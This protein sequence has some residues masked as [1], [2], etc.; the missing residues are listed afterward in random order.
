VQAPRPTPHSPL[1]IPHYF[2]AALVLLCGCELFN[3]KPEIDLQKEIDEKIA[4]AN[5]PWVPVLIDEG[6]LGQA[7]P[8]GTQQ[9]LVKLGYSFS[10]N[11]APNSSFEFRGWQ[12]RLEGGGVPIASWTPLE[13]VNSE[14]VRFVPKNAAA[15]ELEIFVYIRPASLLIIEPLDAHKPFFTVEINAGQLGNISPMGTFS[16][17]AKQGF[18][19]AVSFTPSAAFPFRGWQAKQGGSLIAIW[20]PEGETGADKLRFI[21]QN[22]SGTRVNVAVANAASGETI[23][24]SPLGTD[25]PVLGI[26]IDEGDLGTAIPR[27]QRQEL[28]GFPFQINFQP[29][30]AYPFAGWQARL[31][32]ETALLARWTADASGVFGADRVQFSPLNNDGTMIEALVLVNTESRIVI[33]P[34]GAGSP[35]LQVQVD[36]GALGTA[37]PRGLLAGIRQGFPFTVAFLPAAQYPFKGWQVRLEGEDGNWASWTEEAAQG[38]GRVLWQSRNIT[39]TEMQLTIL[40]NPLDDAGQQ[41]RIIISPL[42]AGS[43]S[44]AVS[45]DYSQDWGRGSQPPSGA[46][47]GFP[48]TLEFVPA[49]D[50][51]FV[52]WLAWDSSVYHGLFADRTA[53]P[54]LSPEEVHIESVTG[55]TGTVTA[56]VTVTGSVGDITLAPWCGQRPR[57]SGSAPPLT[58]N[59]GLYPPNQIVTIEFDGPLDESSVFYGPESIL[60]SAYDTAAKTAYNDIGAEWF[61]QPVLNGGA[62][63]LRPKKNLVSFWDIT[64]T[65]GAGIKR[66]GIG[67][68][69]PVSLKFRIGDVPPANYSYTARQVWAGADMQ[70]TGLF[71]NTDGQ[72][73]NPQIDRRV[74]NDML[75]LYLD[76]Q[77]PEGLNDPPDYFKIVER[78][79]LG[80]DGAA[81]AQAEY[82]EY[83]IPYT[84]QRDTSRIGGAGAYYQRTGVYPYTIVHYMVTSEP[85]TIDIMV[86]PFR[87]GSAY[88]G[89]YEIPP[90]QVEDLLTGQYVTVAKTGGQ[91]TAS[92]GDTA[93]A[94]GRNA[95][96][97]DTDPADDCELTVR[98]N[99]AGPL[100]ASA[101]LEKP[102]TTPHDYWRFSIDNGYGNPGFPGGQWQLTS[103]KVQTIDLADNQNLAWLHESS[104]RFH[105]AAGSTGFSPQSIDSGFT[106][107]NEVPRFIVSNLTDE[108]APPPRS[109]RYALANLPDSAATVTLTGI[110]AGVSKLE[111]KG[112]LPI[113]TKSVTIEGNGLTITRAASWTTVDSSSQL[114]YVNNSSAVITVSISR[115]HFKD[116]RSTSYGGALDNR[117]N[118]TLESCIFSGNQT[119]S[120]AYGGAVYTQENLTLR[121]CTFYNNSTAYQGGAIFRGGGTVTLSGNLF[122]GNTASSDSNGHVVSGN[123]TSTGY[124]VAD[125]P[126]GTGSGQSG[127][128]H[129]NDVNSTGVPLAPLS[130]KVLSGGAAQGI[131]TTLPADYPA[132]DFYGQPI[133]AGASA[134]AVQA[135]AAGA[136]VVITS[137]NNSYG[138][139]SIA[140]TPNADGLYP[141][142]VTLTA[143]GTSGYSLT[144]WLVNGVDSGAGN[145]LNLPLTGHTAVRAEFN[146]V[147]VTSSADAGAGTLRQALINAGNG[148]TITMATANQTIELAS[149]LPDISKNITIDGNG[150]TL[151]RAASWTTVDSNSQLL[152]VSSGAT[153]SI[154]RVHFKDGRATYYGGAVQNYGNL[155]LESCIFSGNQTNGNGGAVYTYSGSLTVRGCTFYQN[156]TVGNGDG[157]GAIL[158][159]GGTVTLLGN[160]FYGNDTG[161]HKYTVVRGTVTSLGYNVV[162]V[163][164]GTGDTAS[165]FAAATGDIVEAAP[166]IDAD[167]YPSAAS[168]EIV[169]QNTP[170][171]PVRDFYGAV[172]PYNSGKTRAGAVGAAPPP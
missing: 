160:L 85:G 142:L 122:Y 156:K 33:S 147:T 49:Q 146:T 48:F 3:N 78:R 115:V 60:I 38:E 55:P 150:L 76:V 106:L 68:A 119:G 109:L 29:N 57:L 6:S 123:G 153:V 37:T 113:I 105:H 152:Q 170:N 41:R 148:D 92:M 80:P 114:L 157:G 141:G 79:R 88:E 8:R 121:G 102:W 126:K 70:T 66:E 17:L 2:L 128:N 96:N 130:F 46:R 20:R 155:T 11:Y 40:D 165:G 31:E 25:N 158:R 56:T 43:G 22:D 83:P 125:R 58:G 74:K 169:P 133:S 111:L 47:Q 53:Y 120:S 98:F 4:Y 112:R 5:A 172:R 132:V 135:T 143:A 171:F 62:I 118:L 72:W 168:V 13:E 36:E 91:F 103:D 67:M 162:D 71:H 75:V 167:F 93:L 77:Y 61:N 107:L 149:R 110:T 104:L 16:N 24:I 99:G 32:G 18:P 97:S 9:Q 117:E 50:Y 30:A 69:Q 26:L 137:T 64:I 82:A 136:F 145:P 101:A 94:A 54:P 1:P 139:I 159:S 87:R 151:T 63:R 39:G 45:F 134:G 95:F 81:L 19:F 164:L 138:S 131:I 161:D 42:G 140:E 127:Y 90:Q 86:L 23:V 84:A 59:T 116:G 51:V 28:M 44:I 34:L 10:L 154:R 108:L 12:A 129:A 73:N 89:E 35:A 166:T 100:E 15:T 52:E 65:L 27:G 144:R 21:P 14:W 163:T 7:N 124:N